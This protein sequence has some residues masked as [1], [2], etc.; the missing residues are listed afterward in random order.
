VAQRSGVKAFFA[1]WPGRL[2]IL[3]LA[4]LSLAGCFVYLGASGQFI[5]IVDLLVFGLVAPI[6]AGWKRPRHLAAFGIVAIVLAAPI[7]AVAAVNYA[8]TPSSPVNSPTLAGAPGPLLSNATVTPYTGSPGD[9]FTFNVTVNPSNVPANDSRPL[10]IELWVSTCPG[11]TGPDDPYC[12]AGY[13]LLDYNTTLN[14][15]VTG[16]Y[17]VSFILPINDTNI[18][19]WQMGTAYYAPI[20]SGNLSWTFL[21]TYAVQGPIVGPYSS[22]LGLGLEAYFLSMLIGP[23]IVFFFGL[24]V[25]MYFKAREARKK[26]AASP[27]TP[28]AVP[29]T[30]PGAPGG[31]PASPPSA[32]PPERACPTCGA[33]VYPN[34]T[35]CWKCGAPLTA[36][37]DAP[38]PSK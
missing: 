21:D 10:W 37:A 35:A 20:S 28:V 27:P 31:P 29:P 32:P 1:S 4:V 38:L 18:W 16:P 23:G 12:S 34:E 3:A 36:A 33:V 25:Y 22:I 17:V 24:L 13:P 30:P 8:Y 26:A 2:V 19:S 5:G 9:T 7:A 15:S 11:A 6:Y 14:L